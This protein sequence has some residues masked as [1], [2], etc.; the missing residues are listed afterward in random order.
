MHIRK[1]VTSSG[2]RIIDTV[3]IACALVAFLMTANSYAVHMAFK[4]K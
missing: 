1:I 2:L 4:H 3:F